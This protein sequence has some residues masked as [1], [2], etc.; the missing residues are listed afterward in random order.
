MASD[1][2]EAPVQD[3]HEHQGMRGTRILEKV[4]RFRD[5]RTILVFSQHG[6]IAYVF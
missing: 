3:G 5:Y 1:D 2:P 6:V 4:D